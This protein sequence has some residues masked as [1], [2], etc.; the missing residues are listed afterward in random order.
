MPR[1]AVIFDSLSAMDPNAT[2]VQEARALLA[3]HGYT[4]TYY[5]AASANLSTFGGLS[6]S[7]PGILLLRTH[8]AIDRAGIQVLFTG[9]SY[10][11]TRHG[12]AVRQGT[13]GVAATT[14][15]GLRSGTERIAAVRPPFLDG[16][17]SDLPASLVVAMGCETLTTPGM[18]QAFLAHGARAYVGWKGQVEGGRSDEAA[19]RLLRNMLEGASVKEAAQ[20]AAAPQSTGDS[21][22]AWAGHGGMILPADVMG[23]EPIGL[24]APSR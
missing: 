16:W 19:L 9:E 2:F 20:D 15:A 3:G 11:A 17:P 12:A 14:L 7:R 6:A 10:N 24:D 4:V 22:F 5:G 23:P 21:G 18:A 1:T 8:A 13:V